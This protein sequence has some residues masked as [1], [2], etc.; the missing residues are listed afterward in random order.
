MKI[1]IAGVGNLLK[2]DDGLG[3]QVVMKLNQ[4]KLPPH[5]DVMDLGTSGM[6]II[7]YSRNYDR[8]IFIDAVKLGKSP[9]TVYRIE[10]REVKETEDEDLRRMI[11]TSMHEV[12]LENVIAVGR[13]LGDMPKDILI[14][15]CEPE[16]TSTMK[17]GLT[18]KVNSA[19]PKIIELILQEIGAC[20]G[21]TSKT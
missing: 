14:I 20:S 4:T 8:I 3:P 19:V 2:C 7:H 6:D 21:Q 15:G 16:D 5:V 18:E 10:P 9:G 11:Y 1:L 13:R 12:D 17:I